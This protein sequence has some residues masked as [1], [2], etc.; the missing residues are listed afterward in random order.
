MTADQVSALM[1]V[2]SHATQTLGWVVGIAV[3]V[4]LA[5]FGGAMALIFRQN[6]ERIDDIEKKAT[7]AAAEAQRVREEVTAVVAHC[8]QSRAGCREQFLTRYVTDTEMKDME[9]EFKDLVHDTLRRLE[10]QLTENRNTLV[11]ALKEVKFDITG[12]VMNHQHDA[13]GSVLIRK[14]DSLR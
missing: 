14:G 3:T 1:A 4:F 10:N 9:K 6:A 12:A 13:G 2:I 8:A 7:S 5:C 11:Q